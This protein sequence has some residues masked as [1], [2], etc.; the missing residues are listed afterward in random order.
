NLFRWLILFFGFWTLLSAI[1]GLVSSRVYSPAD[2]KA[3]L[4][5]MIC[6]DIQLLLGLALYFMNGWYTGLGNMGE[7]M[8]EPMVRFFT[9]EHSIMMIIAWI[10]VHVGRVAVKK[11]FNSSGKFKKSLIFFGISLLLI[12]IAIPWPFREAVS[13]PWFRWF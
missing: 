2:G 4:F 8:K 10:L 9:V 1:S 6:M 12:L 13:R 11:S 3:N 7:S 5:F